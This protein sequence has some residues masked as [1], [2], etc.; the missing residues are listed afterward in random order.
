MHIFIY[1]FVFH[2]E[3][4][5]AILIGSQMLKETHVNFHCVCL[6]ASASLG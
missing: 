6:T 1:Y 3:D 4:D 2:K 5:I